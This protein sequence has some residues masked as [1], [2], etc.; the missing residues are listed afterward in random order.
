MNMYEQ[1]RQSHNLTSTIRGK[2]LQL[3]ERGDGATVSWNRLGT[4]PD[5]RSH[6]GSGFSLF[7]SISRGFTRDMEGE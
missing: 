1:M 2:E 5:W 3:Q 6:V 7:V 4:T